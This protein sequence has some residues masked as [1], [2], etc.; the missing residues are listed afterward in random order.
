MHST[1][2]NDRKLS[3]AEFAARNHVKAPSVRSRVCRFGHYFG[4][5]PERLANGR[6][7]FPDVQVK[8]GD[9]HDA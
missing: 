7:S 4:V 1:G 3:C 2:T 5:K 9:E 6:L 8:K